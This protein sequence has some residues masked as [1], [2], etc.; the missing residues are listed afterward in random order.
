MPDAATAS[1]LDRLLLEMEE[2]GDFPALSR[3]IGEINRAIGDENSRANI[4]TDIILRDIALTKKLLRLVNAAHYGAQ[5]ISTISRAVVILGF[6]AVRDAAVTLMLF[7]HLQNRAHVDELKGEAVD[8]FFRGILGRRLAAAAGVRDGEEAFISALFRDLGR[9]MAR[10]HFFERTEQVRR[11]MADE[12]LGEEAAALRV[13][14]VDYDQLGLAIARRWHFPPAILHAMTP[15]DEASV[16]ASG[17]ES[18]RLRVVANLARDLHKSMAGK[19]PEEQ[20]QAVE[21]LYLR[22]R[23][24]ARV[25]R[26]S[27][28]EHVRKAVESLR[29]EA[30]I[31]SMDV[32]KSSTLPLL[33]RQ[34]TPAAA[35]AAASPESPPAAREDAA[36]QGDPTDVLALGMQDLTALLLGPYHVADVFKTAVEILYRTELFDH[37]LACVLDRPSQALIGRVGLGPNALSMRNAFRIPLGFAPD[38]F[39]AA[40]AKGQDILISDTTADNIRT[41]IPDWHQQTVCAHSF[42]L[43]PIMVEGKPLALFYADRIDAPLQVSNQALG[44]IKALR[45]QTAL[46]LRQKL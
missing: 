30:L 42:L 6:D 9:L 11:L 21:G 31:P 35:T 38:V 4:L 34:G 43:L 33:P 10:F 32:S 3:T 17:S 44:L 39:H 12:L 8:S 5:P 24:A 16:K 13:F 41:R 28:V 7:E 46:A 2:G 25:S 36:A 40:T 14:G 18:G 1:P 19:R 37:V 29:E 15:L 20:E 23:D 45:N 22:Y 26:E 27:L